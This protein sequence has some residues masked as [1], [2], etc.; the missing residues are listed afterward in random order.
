MSEPGLVES[1]D[2]QLPLC[3]ALSTCTGFSRLSTPGEVLRAPGLQE[4]VSVC[5][6]RHCQGA[7]LPSD[8]LLQLSMAGWGLGGPGGL[9]KTTL[10]PELYL[11]PS[12][13]FWG[14]KLL[15]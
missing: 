11:P 13:P 8:A 12:A 1:W 2:T 3:R 5:P 7:L 9:E 4:A 15:V 14:R 10:S 6:A